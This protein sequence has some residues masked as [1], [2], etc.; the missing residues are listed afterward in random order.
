[1]NAIAMFVHA[2]LTLWLNRTSLP[3]PIRPNAWRTVAMIG[4]VLFYGGFSIF[5]VITELQKVLG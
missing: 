5:I 1:M 2:G 4:A 3:R